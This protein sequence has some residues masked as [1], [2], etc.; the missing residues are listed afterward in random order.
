MAAAIAM[1]NGKMR[2]PDRA[3]SP[4]E[5][6]SNGAPRLA[7][8]HRFAGEPQFLEGQLRSMAAFNTPAMYREASFARRSGVGAGLRRELRHAGHIVPNHFSGVS[9]RTVSF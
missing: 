1:P 7:L 4:T 5:V 3:F 8:L 6:E 2:I 9:S